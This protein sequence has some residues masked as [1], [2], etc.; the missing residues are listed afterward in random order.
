MRRSQI[1]QNNPRVAREWI[2]KNC[3]IQTKKQAIV[4]IKLNE[5]QDQFQKVVEALTAANKPIRICALK[6]RQEGIS[7]VTQCNSSYKIYNSSNIKAKTVSYSDESA[8][9]LFDMSERIYRN[10]EPN[11]QPAIRHHTKSSLVFVDKDSTKESLDSKI[12]IDT[13]KNL[14]SGRSQTIHTLHISEMAM[15]QNV[16]KLL[17]SLMNA[18]S[19][20][21]NTFSVVE[22]TAMG[23]DNFFKEFWGK[24]STLKEVLSG[25]IDTDNNKVDYVKLFIPWFIHKEYEKRASPAFRLFNYEHERFG[26]EKELEKIYHWSLD[27]FAWRRWAIVNLCGGDLDIFHQEYPSN[28]LEAFIAG[29]RMR[30]DKPSVMFYVNNVIEPT[31][32]G[33]LFVGES[34]EDA[35]EHFGKYKPEIIF[36]ENPTGL[37][38]IWEYPDDK[39]DYVIGA[40][41]A[42]G[43]E[44]VPG[45][46]KR[47]DYSVASVFKRNPY[48]K[49]AQ[50]RGK[51]ESDIFA[52][53]LYN[54]GWYY[55]LAWI[56]CESN[57]DGIHVNKLLDERYSYIFYKV[58]LNEKTQRKTRKVGWLTD[59]IS[60]PIMIGDF[61]KVVRERLMTNYS[62]DSAQ[63]YMNFVINKRGK[64]EHKFGANDDVVFAD[65]LAL[66]AHIIMPIVSRV[67]KTVK[68][69]VFGYARHRK[70]RT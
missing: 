1:L 52:D 63:E 33:E 39:C 46:S 59:S 13:A 3:F 62:Y 65:A 53:Y 34:E 49:V 21:P 32:T 40:D 18:V 4:L 42:E 64:P 8:N 48:K 28:E 19:P 70:K 5:A 35:H 51:V 26:N 58:I 23:A 20:E 60:R 10:L 55:H 6:A 2:E 41:V 47:T 56:C 68:L 54:L 69:K 14:Y 7:T 11:L 17:I 43:I 22:S 16:S 37:F 50:F 36:E 57:K 66:Q 61:A 12:T 27:K 15:M 44:I 45:D 30:F 25:N 31:A 29:G 38:Q 9:D 24:C 67:H